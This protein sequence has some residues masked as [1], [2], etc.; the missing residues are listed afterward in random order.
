MRFAL[1]VVKLF[2]W[3]GVQRDCLRLARA[4]QDRGHEAT[5]F[6]S[7]AEGSLPA[8]IAIEILPAR[9]LT[10]HGRNRR[11]SDALVRAVKGRYQRVIGFDKL[12]G[13][14][15][16]YCVDPS[17]STHAHVPFLGWFPRHRTLL[18]LEA[19][20]FAKESRTR[21]IGLSQNLFDEYRHAW[22][23]P[24][25]RFTLLPPNIDAARRRPHL[26]TDGTRER[27]RRTLG[28]S[29]EFALLSICVQPEVKGVDRTIDALASLPAALLLVAGVDP[30]GAR[31]RRIM[32][33]AR[34]NG[35]AERV[36]LLGP[37][38]GIPE[39]MAASDLMVHPARL[40]TTGAVILEA[41]VNGLP[42]VTSANC[43]NVVHVQRA[44]A[45]IVLKEPF[46]ARALEQALV[47]AADPA[48]RAQWSANGIA[49][50][51]NP[52]LYRGIER[53]AEFVI[54]DAAR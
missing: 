4:L 11:F 49:Y 36:R 33:I 54:A 21:I 44:A 37:R 40:E 43:G 14:D 48:R 30:G 3:G 28:L 42:Q 31:A 53:A 18:A 38:E 35:V 46:S 10:N 12:V 50:G 51:A 9:A 25:E 13:L 34:A 24:V 45:G 7:S 16:L 19:A 32:E 26:R 2:P 22:G 41:L 29:D 8:D 23:T 6:T 47:D 17:V 5:I 20:S 39:L 15:V 27:L 1:A 52:E